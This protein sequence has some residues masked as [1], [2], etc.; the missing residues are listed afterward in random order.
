MGLEQL[1]HNISTNLLI[2]GSIIFVLKFQLLGKYG[3]IIICIGIVQ[4]AITIEKVLGAVS[5]MSLVCLIY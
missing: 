4:W 1:N 2:G 5:V 3:M